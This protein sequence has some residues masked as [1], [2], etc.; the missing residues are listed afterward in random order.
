MWPPL[1]IV[2]SVDTSII[3]KANG[4]KSVTSLGF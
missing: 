1:H 4:L 2:H 3:I